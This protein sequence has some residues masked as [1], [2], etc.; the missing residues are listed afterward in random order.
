MTLRAKT[1]HKRQ[2]NLAKGERLSVLWTKHLQEPKAKEDFEALLR[3]STTIAQRLRQLIEEFET[4][5]Q[6]KETSLSEYDTPSWSY[7]QAHM[8][9]QRSAYT[10]IKNL[11]GEI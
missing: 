1:F 10:R 9:G 3:N 7:K 11:L 5:C 8:N 2:I 6:S 4:E